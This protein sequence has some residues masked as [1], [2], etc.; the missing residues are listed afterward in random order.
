MCASD[1]SPSREK[2]NRAGGADCA[3]LDRRR[4]D[5]ADFKG[6]SYTPLDNYL[7]AVRE[8]RREIQ[9]RL[10]EVADL[11]ERHP[12]SRKP[13][14]HFAIPPSEYRVLATTDEERGSSFWRDMEDEGWL[15]VDHVR[16]INLFFPA[17]PQ[18]ISSLY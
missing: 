3:F 2:L 18:L 5:F 14:Q 9:R 17:R 7:E 10:S 4:K 15:V 6:F 8:V 1:L 12:D 11:V 16:H 13:P